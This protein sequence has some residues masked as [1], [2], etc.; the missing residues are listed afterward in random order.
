MTP[1]SPL[2]ARIAV[3][4]IGLGFA[5]GASAF[6]QDD[7]VATPDFRQDTVVRARTNFAGSP[8]TSSTLQVASPEAVDRGLRKLAGRNVHNAEGEKLGTIRDFVI[9]KRS[10]AVIYAVVSSGGILGVRQTLRLVPIGALQP[11]PAG[12]DG[13]IIRINRVGWNRAPALLKAAFNA[14]VIRIDDE[15]MRQM[16][17]LFAEAG[18]FPF[19]AKSTVTGPPRDDAIA[20]TEPETQA[21]P[22][23]KLRDLE[24]ER[25]ASPYVRASDLRDRDIRASGQEVGE[26]EDIIIDLE[27][28]RAFALVELDE[29]ITERELEVLVPINRLDLSG[30]RH[31][32]AT[33]LSV[34]DF[35]RADPNYVALTA[36]PPSASNPSPDETLSPT[37][38]ID[39]AT[40][41]LAPSANDARAL[42]LS[43]AR[44]ALTR[45]GE[46]GGITILV[47]A[48]NGTLR[49]TGTVPSERHKQLAADVVQQAVPGHTIDNQLV[50]PK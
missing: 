43:A 18:A 22:S 46:L 13:Y 9:D 25:S 10:G 17:E 40:P 37:G 8:Q 11:A 3:T 28:R 38:R 12:L 34:A 7:D 2:R 20:Q 14:G 33:N 1:L 39:E 47:T 35:Q 49:F 45:Q 41:K 4:A 44:Q 48:E 24:A 42:A 16:S 36:A 26:V 6:A 19:S 32:L 5:F 29:D 27:T 15:Q 30:T 50:V 31:Q 23:S 21:R